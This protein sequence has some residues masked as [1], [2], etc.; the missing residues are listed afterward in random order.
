MK[1]AQ[2]T[3]IVVGVLVIGGVLSWVFLAAGL[4]AWFLDRGG[5]GESSS[6]WNLGPV[7]LNIF[8]W[9]RSGENQREISVDISAKSAV[10]EPPATQGPGRTVG[11]RFV[12][13]KYGFSLEFP[14]GFKSST[15]PD[16]KGELVVFEKSPK[17]GLQ[18][19]IAPFDTEGPLTA[20]FIRSEVPDMPMRNIKTAKLDSVPAVVFES[21][22]ES[23]GAT[24]E[25]WLAHPESPVPHG[26]YLYQISTYK[27]FAGEMTEILQSWKFVQ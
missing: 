24:L 21:S 14:E 10:V 22:N 16:E 26:N 17:E 27:E 2:V 3:S 19:Y 1:K 15:F 11:N 25:I 8:G 5:E 6:G 23:I 18:I 20:Q 7:N 4:G 13:E 9:G 12:S